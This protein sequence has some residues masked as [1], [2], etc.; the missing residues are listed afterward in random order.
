MQYSIDPEGLDGVDE[1]ESAVQAAP[2]SGVAMPLDVESVAADP[3]EA[4]K[5]RVELLAEIFLE[6]GAVAL[7]EAGMKEITEGLDQTKQRIV[8][9]AAL[10]PLTA[11]SDTGCG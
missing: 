10:E 4:R 7:D 1:I 8:D 11:L 6:V 2:F 5:R 9:F 3:V